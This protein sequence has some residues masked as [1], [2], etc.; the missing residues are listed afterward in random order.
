MDKTDIT[1]EQFEA[2]VKATGGA[3][4]PARV[5]AIRRRQL[6]TSG[7][8][9][10]ILS[11]HIA[12]DDAI[13]YCKWAGATQREG[14]AKANRTRARIIQGLASYVTWQPTQQRG[15]KRQG[16]ILR[17]DRDAHGRKPRIEIGFSLRPW[18]P[19]ESQAKARRQAGRPA[20]Q[21]FYQEACATVKLKTVV[22]SNRAGPMRGCAPRLSRMASADWNWREWR[23]PNAISTIS[24]RIRANAPPKLRVRLSREQAIVGAVL[25]RR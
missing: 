19:G 10:T 2:F 9:G 5:G 23:L 14:G 20:P 24:S 12:Y 25:P 6:R 22:D 11:S 1:N 15:R 7:G 21:G 13:A 18:A 3:I 16:E 8:E 4:K 17:R